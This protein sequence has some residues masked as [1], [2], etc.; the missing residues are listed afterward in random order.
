LVGLKNKNEQLFDAG[1]SGKQRM[2]K[3]EHK[4]EKFHAKLNEHKI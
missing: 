2:H 1:C 3:L 4:I